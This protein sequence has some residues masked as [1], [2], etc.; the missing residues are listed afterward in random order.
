MFVLQL[1]RRAA[2]AVV[3][4]THGWG[5]TTTESSARYVGLFDFDKAA[6]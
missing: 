3:K 5:A 2:G 1:I 6:P 4:R